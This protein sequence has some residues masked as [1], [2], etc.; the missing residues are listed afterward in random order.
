MILR[1]DY[2]LVKGTF[3]GQRVT[4]RIRGVHITLRFA[5]TEYSGDAF[6]DGSK[7][8]QRRRDAKRRGSPS[9]LNHA[10]NTCAIPISNQTLRSARP[11]IQNCLISLTDRSVPCSSA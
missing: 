10:R 9:V 8:R 6:A 3:G 11:E 4:G 5:N 7:A 2:Q 1:Q